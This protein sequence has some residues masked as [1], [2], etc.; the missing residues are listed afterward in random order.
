MIVDLDK[1][2]KIRDD[3]DNASNKKIKQLLKKLKK[4]QDKTVEQVAAIILDNMDSDGFFVLSGNQKEELK[5]AI[6]KNL[7]DASKEEEEFLEELL[8]DAY[9]E[10]KNKTSTALGI[11]KDFSLVRPEMVAKAINTPI[12]GKRFSQRI[13]DNNDALANRIYEDVL[14]CVKN[15]T[16]PNHIARK[17]KKDFGVTAYQAKR[18]INTE[19][20]KVVNA[21]QLEIYQSEGVGKVM[22]TATL[23]NNTCDYCAD[24]DGKLFDVNNAP[25]NPAHP[26]CRCCFVP[27]V[28][29]WSPKYRADNET[30]TKIEYK[31]FAEW[32]KNKQ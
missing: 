12:D 29:G 3:L 28:A 2:V 17:I 25:S 30:K 11:K 26:C 27:V 9:I 5:K 31:T 19:L 8:E 14:D 1:F 32:Q 7:S 20:A 6:A 4:C 16:R 23:E 15:G 10:T 18:L 24:M 13:W 22:W 21:A